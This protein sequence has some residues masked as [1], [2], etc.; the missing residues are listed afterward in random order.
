M[1]IGKSIRREQRRFEER[2]GPR[3]DNRR[4]L[5]LQDELRV[6]RDRRMVQRFKGVSA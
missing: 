5:R 4:S 6:Q 2:N 1:S 3:D